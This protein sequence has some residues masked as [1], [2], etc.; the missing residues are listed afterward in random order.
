MDTIKIR[1]LDFTEYPGVRYKDQGDDTGEDFYYEK[2]KPTFEKC[3]RENKKLIVDLD[4]TAGYASSFL[5]ECFGNLVYDFPYN[6]IINR[7][8]IIT[9][10]EPDWKDV[11]F[12]ETL[13]QWL[14]KLNDGEPRK[15]V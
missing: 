8:E 6:E 11:I 4:D 7:L 14:R 13:P 3:I 12:E 15:P 9:T 10:Q 5:D 2:I 1:V